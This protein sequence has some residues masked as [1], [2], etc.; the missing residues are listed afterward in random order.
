M[1]TT[2]AMDEY[3][4][5][6]YKLIMITVTGACSCAGVTLVG[7]KVLGLYPTVS[8][9]ALIIF[10]GTCL[11][12]VGIG[13]L[14]I[15]RCMVNGKLEPKMLHYGKVFLLIIL[16]VQFNF[17]QYMIPSRD[18]WA[19]AF[20]FVILIA[21]FLDYKIILILIGEIGVS[22][23]A[24]FIIN[25]D[26][27]LPVRDELFIP[28]LVLRSIC[29]VLSFFAI[30]LITIFAGKFL[31]DA[32]RDELDKSNAQVSNF[33]AKIGQL[34]SS[35]E[36]SSTV[37]LS[38]L[39]NESATTESLAQIT[40]NLLDSN[41]DMLTK[42]NYNKENLGELSNSSSEMAGQM[43]EVDEVSQQLVSI[44]ADN[45]AALNNLMGISTKV[46]QSTQTTVEVTDKL[47]IETDKIGTTLDIINEIAE[48]INLLSLNASIE[49][50]RAGTAGRGFAV[51][52]D[53]ISKL[54]VDAQKSAQEIQG[55]TTLVTGT[56]EELAGTAEEMLKFMQTHMK[57]TYD[58]LIL[59]SDHYNNDASYFNDLLKNI[60]QGVD[61]VSGQVKTVASTFESFRVST[62]EGVI[63]INGVA[64]SAEVIAEST[65]VLKTAGENMGEVSNRL[66]ETMSKFVV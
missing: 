42:S 50:A 57:G 20:F 47:L 1:S 54:A 34:S 12:Y 28:E 43:A 3:M 44:S 56:V 60:A 21:L 46:E 62:A 49:A 11:C 27:L 33:L 23:V 37:I 8:W 16:F 14:L 10:V 59:T 65:R 55:I 52:A 15:S 64:E 30:F 13:I 7:L 5:K 4:A 35:L 48:S 6:V 63:G 40:E 51:V 39:Q 58:K 25:G 53:E 22:L 66:V 2:T 9:A 31:G 17:I 29:I 18:F 36:S 26:N 45:E 32:K 61:G 19:Y 41:N 38:S 24:A